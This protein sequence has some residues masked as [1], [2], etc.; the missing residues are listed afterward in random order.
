MERERELVCYVAED[1]VAGAARKLDID[2][3][4]SATESDECLPFGRT[5]GPMPLSVRNGTLPHAPVRARARLRVMTSVIRFHALARSSRA[6]PRRHRVFHVFRDFKDT[7]Y[8]FF[9]SYAFFLEDSAR[10]AS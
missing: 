3:E 10:A 8:P 2:S 6:R 4:A 7:V 9:E 5:R 1:H